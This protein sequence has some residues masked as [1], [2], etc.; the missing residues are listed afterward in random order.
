MQ[1]TKRNF[2]HFK[3]FIF[4]LPLALSSRWLPGNVKE[5]L[6]IPEVVTYGTL[7]PGTKRITLSLRGGLCSRDDK[8]GTVPNQ[9]LC[10]RRQVMCLSSG[11]NWS[12]FTREDDG[13]DEGQLCPV[14]CCAI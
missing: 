10:C 11:N 1:N 4:A 14:C 2:Y 9:S 13:F 3:C 5:S 7:V 6:S 12:F 8:L